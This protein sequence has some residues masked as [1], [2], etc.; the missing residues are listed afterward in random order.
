MKAVAGVTSYD[1]MPQT[2]YTAYV[3]PALI[4]RLLD[5]GSGTKIIYK[6]RP[7]AK[8]IE[9]ISSTARAT[10]TTTLNT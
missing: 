4:V 2:S 9:I 6:P 7:R 10:L 5:E 1:G 3:N 8:A